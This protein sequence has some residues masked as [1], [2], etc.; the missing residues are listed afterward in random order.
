M[1]KDLWALH[2]KTVIEALEK[3]QADILLNNED[4]ALHTLFDHWIHILTLLYK[5]HTGQDYELSNQTLTH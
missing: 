1:D 5:E 3:L 4:S 2:L